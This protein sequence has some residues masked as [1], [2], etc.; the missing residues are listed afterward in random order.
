MSISIQT[1]CLHIEK[2]DNGDGPCHF[3]AV[4][5]PIYQTATFA[6]PGA[7]ESTG[8]DYSRLQNPTREH[9]EKI[10]CNLESGIDALALSSGMAA[11][12]LVFE[13]F[14][15]GDE[16]IAESDLY[17]GSIRLF[18]NVSKK[19]GV[20]IIS[21]EISR[22]S[23]GELEK[24]ITSSTRAI[25]IETPTNPMMNI[26]DIK[27]LAEITK[28]HN[29]LLIVDNTFMSP[30]FQNPL[31][32][33]ADIVIHSGTKYLSGHNDTLSGFVVTNR[34]DIKEKLRFLIKTTGAGL[35]PFD[36]WLTL[37]GIKTLAVRMEKAQSN[38]IKIVEYL[39]KNP[40]IKKVIYPGLKE[41][42]G[43]EIQ[44][45]QA[46]GTG[47]MITFQTDSKETTLS[48]LNK[49]RLIQFAESLGGVESL[50]TYPVTQTHADVPEVIRLKNGITDTTLRLSVGIEDADDLINDLSQALQAD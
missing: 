35:S 29:L 11:I 20:K 7:G 21:K 18:D 28:K 9:L 2:E 6:H 34:G 1:K 42:P 4:S 48:I 22:T 32:L 23:A 12:S 36:S 31:L 24:S 16:I 33:G 5:F 19:N 10:V 45:K 13:L 46:R 25:Y 39:K 38:A 50:I 49:V 40:H 15:P 37:R 26:T 14:S 27:S 43:Y 47:C 30:Y 44:K 8:F 3:G 17:G 41:H